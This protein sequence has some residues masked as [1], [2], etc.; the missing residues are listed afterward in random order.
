[1]EKDICISCDKSWTDECHLEKCW[2]NNYS[3][4]INDE[5]E[6]DDE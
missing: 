2:D 1:M 5:V 6:N 4:Y 3:E